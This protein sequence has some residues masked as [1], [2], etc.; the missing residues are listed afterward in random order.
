MFDQG[1]DKYYISNYVYNESIV[2]R[3]LP[4][5]A[6]NTRTLD[7]DNNGN[8]G[9]FI[10]PMTLDSNL[11]VLYSDYSNGTT[12]RVRRYTNIKSG[13]IGRTDLTDPLLTAP[14]TALTVSPFTT[15]SSTLLVGTRLG[16]LLKI[17]SAQTGNGIW[18]DITGSSFVGS[19][20]DVEYGTTENEI[21]VTMHNYNVVSIWYTA[22]G[23][24]TWV[25]KEGNLPD[26][27][28]K[29]ILKNP[30]NANEVIV[31]TEL[32]VWYTNNFNTTTPTWNQSYNGMSN[33]KVLDLD[34]RN[35]NRVY[36]ATYGRGIFSGTFTATSLSE[37]DTVFNKGVKV[38]PNPSNGLFTIAIENFSG[39][40]T[41]AIYD[42]NGRN[43]FSKT[44]DYLTNNNVNLSGLQKGIYILNIKGANLSYSEKI[45]L[46]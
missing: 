9:A 36:A 24:I 26:L 32:G 35:D 18:S 17:S 30:L 44:G 27:P 19:I 46:Q 5:S 23:G 15:T 25:S 43:V 2:L 14:P 20:S 31:G 3:P 1:A 21:F 42:I 7:A 16:K 37:N 22:N 45:I 6:L 13:A 10:A 8:N 29:C 28:V 12:Y 40:M 11:D 41:L 33:V 38:Y 39:D 34:L 4:G